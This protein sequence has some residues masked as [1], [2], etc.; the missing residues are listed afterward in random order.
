M[1]DLLGARQV[2]VFRALELH[3]D[4]CEVVVGGN[5]DHVQR[6]NPAGDSRCG[7]VDDDLQR[8]R[9]QRSRHVF[10]ATWN[11]RDG[12]QARSGRRGLE[13]QGRGE[14]HFNGVTTVGGQRTVG[15]EFLAVK[16]FHEDAD[17]PR[18]RGLT[19]LVDHSPGERQ[20]V[21]LANAASVGHGPR[22]WLADVLHGKVRWREHE[23]VF[24]TEGVLEQQDAAG[25]VAAQFLVH[26][27][28]IAHLFV[29]PV[30]TEGEM[31]VQEDPRQTGLVGGLHH[32]AGWEEVD[33]GGVRP[34]GVVGPRIG[35]ALGVSSGV[36]ALKVK[37]E[38]N[39]FEVNGGVGVDEAQ[40]NGLLHACKDR[41]VV[42]MAEPLQ[43]GEDG[44]RVLSGSEGCIVVEEAFAR[45][46]LQ[47]FIV[48]VHHGEVQRVSG[49]VT[50]V[51][52]IRN[53]PHVGVARGVD[54]GDEPLGTSLG[55]VRHRL[56]DVLLRVG[57]TVSVGVV[58][59]LDPVVEFEFHGV[60]DLVVHEHLNRLLVAG[61]FVGVVDGCDL[62]ALRVG[63]VNEEG[64]S[65]FAV[66]LLDVIGVS[67]VVGL[68]LVG[69]TVRNVNGGQVD[70]DEE[71]TVVVG[72][73]PSRALHVTVA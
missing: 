54:G 10:T 18:R 49:L 58:V 48:L 6:C 73:V 12:N 22:P 21:V 69:E 20:A 40:G 44:G 47:E 56:G 51:P 35:N 5:V 9:D 30:P 64:A 19:A 31:E 61:G 37:H 72:R 43:A 16:D 1:D 27:G 62:L 4:L 26:Q 42:F 52:E 15:P 11:V 50:A 33:V 66:G 45:L 71:R 63:G 70:R 24:D 59:G 14:R 53:S 39:E 38:R 29:G 57:L 23:V 67:F 13:R 68:D 28:H 7:V 34:E 17:V 46:E 32:A 55:R 2:G 65:P 3:F 60:A 25:V 8:G 36:G 41:F